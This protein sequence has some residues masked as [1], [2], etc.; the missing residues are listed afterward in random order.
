MK[1]VALLFVV[2]ILAGCSSGVGLDTYP[3]YKKSA[4]LLGP[5]IP[6]YPELGDFQLNEGT[7]T[8]DALLKSF[9]HNGS[10]AFMGRGLSQTYFEIYPGRAW[11]DISFKS[12]LVNYMFGVQFVQVSGGGVTAVVRNMR[13]V[14]GYPVDSKVMEI[15]P[16]VYAA[17]V[18]AQLFKPALASEQSLK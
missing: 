1:H 3:Y 11:C 13:T 8:I 7:P 16:K 12:G 2:L 18:D 4:G 5:G 15:T 6:R 14:E 9:S 17:L 10:K